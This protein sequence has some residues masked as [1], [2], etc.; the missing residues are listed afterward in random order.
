VPRLSDDQREDDLPRIAA[1]LAAFPEIDYAP[2]R[3]RHVERRRQGSFARFALCFLFFLLRGLTAWAG[4]VFTGGTG[5]R[6]GLLPAAVGTPPT[7]SVDAAPPSPATPAADAPAFSVPADNPIGL[8][9]ERWGVA[10]CLPAIVQLSDFLATNTEASWR[11]VRGTTDP[12]KQMFAGTIVAR[13]KT[14][15]LRGISTLFATP[16]T[17]GRCNSGYDL[18]IIFPEPCE[19]AR[20]RRQPGFDTRANLGPVAEVYLNESGRGSVAYMPAGP[21]TCILV[22][23]EFSY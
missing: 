5:D 6:F 1:P 15:G 14:T 9:A 17:S 2:E 8:Q 4:L 18:I 20:L 3:L 12:D 22:R 16:A 21:G 11:L 7:E 23:T 19:Q 10:A 13:D